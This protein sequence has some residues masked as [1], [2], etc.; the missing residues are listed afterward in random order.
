[1]SKKKLLLKEILYNNTMPHT[2]F[3]DKI[4]KTVKGNG[5]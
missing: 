1:M 2:I 5:N 3:F 4:K